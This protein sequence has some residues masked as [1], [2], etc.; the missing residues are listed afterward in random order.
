MSTECSGRNHILSGLMDFI[1]S[2]QTGNVV[3]GPQRFLLQTQYNMAADGTWKA[4]GRKNSNMM[5]DLLHD[6]EIQSSCSNVCNLDFTKS[7][8]IQ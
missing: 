1:L 5:W 7:I 4:S 3:W 2:V 8:G 6:S